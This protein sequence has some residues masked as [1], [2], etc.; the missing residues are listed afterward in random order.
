MPWKVGPL[1][2]ALVDDSFVDLIPNAQ[3]NVVSEIRDLGANYGMRVTAM[4]RQIRAIQLYSPVDKRSSLST[5]NRTMAIRSAK[6]G[7]AR[8][9]AW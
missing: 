9:P 4:S 3:G 7:T 6:S 5:R 8:I 2:D 1:P